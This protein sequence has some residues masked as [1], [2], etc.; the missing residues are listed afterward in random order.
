MVRTVIN[1]SHPPLSMKE[2]SGSMLM[3]EQDRARRMKKLL[4]NIWRKKISNRIQA[5]MHIKV[6]NITCLKYAVGIYLCN[7]N[8]MYF[9][10][11]QIFQI[12]E[13]HC[14]KFQNFGTLIYFWTRSGIHHTFNGVHM[15]P[16][17]LQLLLSGLPE[18]DQ[19]TKSTNSSYM[20]IGI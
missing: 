5:T 10:L 3:I 4:S 11:K 13:P 8:G 2:D 19:I 17:C 18:L 15:K 7:M 14:A 1:Q 12:T 9:Q 20:Q 16:A 6:I